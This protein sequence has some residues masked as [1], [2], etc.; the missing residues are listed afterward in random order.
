MCSD[1]SQPFQAQLLQ[2]R[3]SSAFRQFLESLLHLQWQDIV[4]LKYNPMG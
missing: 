2:E 4:L 3:E 1:A